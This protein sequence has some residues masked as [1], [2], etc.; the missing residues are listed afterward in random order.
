MPCEHPFVLY[1]KFT[2]QTYRSVYEFP[3]L[4]EWT[5]L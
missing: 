4:T 3:E 1:M 2:N 5:I